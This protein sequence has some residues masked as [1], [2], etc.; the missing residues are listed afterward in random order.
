M[1]STASFYEKNAIKLAKQYD[2]L[3]FES[4]HKSWSAYWPN[5]GVKVLDVG[6][7]SGR[8][9]RWFSERGCSVVA[10]EPSQYLREIGKQNC[11]DKVVWLADSLPSL[12]QAICLVEQ[13]DVVLLSAVWMHLPVNQRDMAI[14]VLSNLLSDNGFWSLHCAT[15]YLKTVVRPLASLCLNWKGYA[16]MLACSSFM[17]LMMRMRCKEKKCH[18]KPLS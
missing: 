10:I 18:G 9:A 5:S 2:S 1:S 8:D 12:E 16:E 3:K 7:G 11:S 4:V 15:V 6:A 17:T 14:R 13:Y